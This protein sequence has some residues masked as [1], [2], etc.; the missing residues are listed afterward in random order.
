M[1]FPGIEWQQ[2]YYFSLQVRQELLQLI[3]RA[4]G[5]ERQ[6][7]RSSSNDVRKDLS[8]KP[9]DVSN[10]I[11]PCMADIKL[12]FSMGRYRYLPSSTQVLL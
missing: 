10:L 6:T 5:T 4:L 2:F 11:G 3:L 7:D 12:F 8:I 9:N 1:A